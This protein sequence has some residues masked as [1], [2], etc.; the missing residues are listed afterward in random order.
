MTRGPLPLFSWQS[1]RQ[2][3][4]F[5]LTK[6]VG[7]TRRTAQILSGKCGDGA[8]IYWKQVTGPTN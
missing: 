5:P 3:L 7:T 4:L 6:R 2:V 1:P 8:S